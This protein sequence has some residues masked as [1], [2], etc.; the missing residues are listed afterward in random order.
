LKSV[1]QRNI[2]RIIIV[3]TEPFPLGMAAT[4]RIISWAGVIATSGIQI[5]TYIIKPTENPNHI[6]NKFATGVHKGISFEYVNKTTIWPKQRSKLYKLFTLFKGYYL[7]IRCIKRDSPAI[8][9][10]YT[11]D[12][13]IEIILLL[14]RP[15]LKYKIVTEET[16]YPKILKKKYCR[17]ITNLYLSI[18]RFSDGML[19]I[20]KELSDYYKSIGAKNVFYLPMTV[21]SSRFDNLVKVTTNQPFFLYVGG[22]GGFKRDGVFDIIKAF[23]LFSIK[24]PT[25]KFIVVGPVDETNEE[26]KKMKSYI[27]DN[28]LNNKILFTGSKS[29]NDIPQLLADATG[30]VMAPPKNFVSGGFPT[31]LGEF[32]AAGTPVICTRVSDI[33][34]YLNEANSYLSDP[35]DITSLSILME[36]IILYPEISITKGQKGKE[37]AQS[38]FNAETYKNSLLKHLNDLL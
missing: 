35:G 33:P 13:I 11:N 30:I 16:E 24:Y 25:Y 27:S 38:V 14:I 5:K 32:L 28:N 2:F 29:T 9:V 15:F 8:V 36:E 7:M 18:Y 37:L 20:T 6:Q 26:F 4:N 10:T 34:L 21:D 1:E 3:T 12:N 31:K 17:F 23:H 19:V 22:S